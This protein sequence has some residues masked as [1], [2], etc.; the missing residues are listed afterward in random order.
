MDAADASRRD[1]PLGGGVKLGGPGGH[2]A[3]YLDT[4]GE[5]LLVI[6][7][8][9]SNTVLGLYQGP[10]VVH[11]WRVS[12]LQRTTDE[13][14][15]M[16]LQLFAHEGVTIAEVSGVAVCSVVPSTIYAIEKASRRYFKRTARVLGKGADLGM[17]IRV[18]NPRELGPD[19]VVNCIAA[20]HR[21]EPPF[22]IVDFGTA[23]TFDAVDAS[24]AYVGGAIAPGLQISA[25][26]LFQR[27]SRLPRVEIVEPPRPIGTNTISAM[28]S[29]LFWGYV[30]LV[31]GLAR[32]CKEQLAPGQRVPCVATGGLANLVG[33][34]CREIDDVDEHLT[35]AGLRLWF[36]RPIAEEAG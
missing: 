27:T 29:G 23:T 36:E 13:F 18:D 22:L 15:L 14:G 6:D 4:V 17:A 31:D 30:G 20:M 16:V 10:R 21:F 24:G 34:A 9:N 7:V 3:L 1:D 25:D 12:T 5:M 35:L 11:T 28:Q 2:V 26:A 32:R 19:R 33:R 8:G